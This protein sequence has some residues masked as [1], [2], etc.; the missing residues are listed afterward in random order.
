MAGRKLAL[1]T[2]DW[3][4]F[5]EIIPQNQKAI[6]SSLKSW[7]ETLT[8][9]LAALPE[10]PPAIDWAYY[11]ANVA[12]A[13]LVDDFEKKVKSCAEWVSLSKARIVEHEKEMEKMK[14]L[15]PFDQMTIEDLN[16]AFP[17]TKLD[18]KKYPY[19]PHQPIENL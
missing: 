17:E 1:K 2:I 7:N 10:N 6:A 9:R 12:K 19:W 11:K 16:E 5:A 13:G 3:V 14:N 18:K 15:I 8:S 4:A